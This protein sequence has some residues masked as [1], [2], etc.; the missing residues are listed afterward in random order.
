MTTARKL[1]DGGLPRGLTVDQFVAWYKEQPGRYELHDGD[2]YAM[3]PARVR[4]SVMK[5]RAYTALTDAVQRAGVPC[6]VMPDGIAVHVSDR[7][8]YEPDALVYCG[9]EA[10]DDDISI[11]NPVIVVEVASPSTV[12]LD[13]TAKLSGYFDVPSVQHYLIVYPDKPVVH[14]QRQADGTI[15][16]RLLSTGPLRLDPPGLDLDVESLLQ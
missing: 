4:H 6:H 7:K 3:S 15:L 16:T 5:G 8:W 9:P 11:A 1:P 12:R 14:H 13:E 10:P 2:V